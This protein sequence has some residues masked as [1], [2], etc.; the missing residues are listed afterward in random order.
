MTPL[1]ETMIAKV[2]ELPAPEQDVIAQRILDELNDERQWE[3][4]FARSQDALGRLA[5]KVRQDIMDN[6]T[7][8]VGVDEL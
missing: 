2:R 5:A 7:R 8:L 1:L 3:E 4:A 6:K